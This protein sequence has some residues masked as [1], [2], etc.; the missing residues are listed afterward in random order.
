MRHYLQ[1]PRHAE[2]PYGRMPPHAASPELAPGE[3]CTILASALSRDGH[4]PIAR[5]SPEDERLALGRVSAVPKPLT[6]PTWAINHQSKPTRAN[7]EK[8]GCAVTSRIH[9]TPWLL[10]DLYPQ[11]FAT[12]PGT[13]GRA[14][15]F[16]NRVMPRQATADREF[17]G[18]PSELDDPKLVCHGARFRCQCSFLRRSAAATWSM[19]RSSPCH[20]TTQKPILVCVIGI[21]LEQAR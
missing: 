20:K 4:D 15:P 2:A 17:T 10:V 6:L 12:A 21:T 11:P 19:P 3:Q 14:V 16:V 18:L 13:P 8:T 5:G 9:Q 7:E 1:S